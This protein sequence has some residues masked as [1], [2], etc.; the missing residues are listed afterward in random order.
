V[1]H[2][3]TA[4]PMTSWTLQQ[5]QEALPEDPAYRSV[6][7]DPRSDLLEGTGPGCEEHGR[8]RIADACTISDGELLLRTGVSPRMPG[9][10]DP[11]L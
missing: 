8:A 11:V 4:H 3:V 9:F 5:F 1:Y 6:I 10:S 2:N 7:H